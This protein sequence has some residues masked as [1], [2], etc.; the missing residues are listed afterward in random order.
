MIPSQ[1]SPEAKASELD[2]ARLRMASLGEEKKR[3]EFELGALS[4]SAKRSEGGLALKRQLWSIEREISKANIFIKSLASPPRQVEAAPEG[5]TSLLIKVCRVLRDSR[6]W[7]ST[8][9]ADRARR[10][11]LVEIEIFLERGGGS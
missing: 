5:S 4:K 10:E 9:H 6:R 3:V 2:L 8:A 11:L 7:E 1:V